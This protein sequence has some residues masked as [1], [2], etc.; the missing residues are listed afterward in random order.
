M[1]EGGDEW[2]SVRAAM[3]IAPHAAPTPFKMRVNIAVA[4]LFADYVWRLICGF[5][6]EAADPPSRNITVHCQWP[7]SEVSVTRRVQPLA[8]SQ[9]LA[10]FQ[11]EKKTTHPPPA[12]TIPGRTH[13]S[14]RS[15]PVKGKTR[16]SWSRFENNK[17]Q[18]S[19][20]FHSSLS[21][22]LRCAWVWLMGA[23]F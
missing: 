16:P 12:D 15:H 1:N 19:Q 18:L 11:H 8:A 14:R 22:P 23:R 4:S 20:T 13:R 2:K 5:K 17:V 3:L 9:Y 7:G 6:E 10:E 21:A